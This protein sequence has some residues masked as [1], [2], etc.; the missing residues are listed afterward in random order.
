MGSLIKFPVQ[1][2]EKQHF[3]PQTVMEAEFLQRLLD[4]GY[5]RSE[6][7]GRMWEFRL[8]VMKLTEI[9]AREYPKG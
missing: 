8:N 6:I 7:A 4:L 1:R 5:D 9:A 3:N 2:V